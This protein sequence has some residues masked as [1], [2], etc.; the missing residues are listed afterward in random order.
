MSGQNLRR[1]IL[2]VGIHKGL[3]LTLLANHGAGEVLKGW[4]GTDEEARLAIVEDPR[5]YIVLDPAC[6]RQGPD[7]ACLGHEVEA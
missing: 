6:D 7:G 2:H 5:E 4:T 1:R 3:L